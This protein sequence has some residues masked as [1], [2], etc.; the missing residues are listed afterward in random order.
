MLESPKYKIML[1]EGSHIDPSMIWT[2]ILIIIVVLLI[3]FGG[4]ILLMIKGKSADEDLDEDDF[5][6]GDDE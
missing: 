6:T 4:R 5:V 1:A 2:I 3:I